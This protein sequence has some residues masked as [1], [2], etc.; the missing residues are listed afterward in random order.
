MEIK[1]K[2]STDT[3]QI[4]SSASSSKQSSVN[5]QELT[6]SKVINKQKFEVEIDMDLYSDYKESGIVK[7]QKTPKI[8]ENKSL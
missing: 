6:V 2:D 1:Q 5:N 7:Y 4:D 3:T 8:V